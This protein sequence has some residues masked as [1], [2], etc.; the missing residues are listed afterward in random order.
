MYI[1][2]DEKQCRQNH[3]HIRWRQQLVWKHTYTYLVSDNNSRARTRTHTRIY[4]VHG[5]TSQH[6]VCGGVI[7]GAVDTCM[8]RCSIHIHVIQYNISS[9]TVCRWRSGLFI[10]KRTLHPELSTHNILPIYPDDPSNVLVTSNR[11]SSPSSLTHFTTHKF[12]T[13]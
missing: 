2:R 3:C 8:W 7:D 9:S 5:I 12:S 1:R 4:I 6:F 13:M 10:L 11:W